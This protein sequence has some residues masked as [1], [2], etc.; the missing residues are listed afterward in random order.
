MLSFIITD[1][2]TNKLKHI[3][4]LSADKS[5][6]LNSLSTEYR[7]AI[8]AYARISTIGSTTRIENAVLTDPEIKWLDETLRA[9]GRPTAFLKEKKYIENKLSKERERS[10]EEVA[11]CRNMLAIIYTQAPDLFP[12]TE[13]TIRGFH[14]ELL[15]F[16]PPAVHYLG[17]YK[18][19]PNNVVETI[20]GTNIKRD[21]LKTSHPGPI[22]D[23][24]MRDLVDWYNKTLPDHPWPI[25]VASEFVFRFL[26]IHP[27]QDGNGRIG[28]ALF[29]LALLQSNEKNLKIVIPYI[30]L[31]RHIEKHKEEYYL[32]LRRCSDGKFLQ[33]SGKYKLQY[34]LI[35][36]LKMLDEAIS[37]DIDFYANKYAS[38]IKLAD[39]PRKVLSCFEHYP[40]KK[41]ALKD[42]V[43]ETKI[44]RRT[45]IHALNVLVS[46]NFLQKS[47][48][49]PA[50]K[51]QITF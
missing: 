11:G 8:H 7:E 38:F 22:T 47:G 33:D 4:E 18:I 45:A 5:S 26:A 39:A 9:D 35:F 2:I 24:A 46:K 3:D 31:D 41:L 43:G 23:A 32:V 19:V 17:K 30:A 37:N 29:H 44:S 6:S 50:T 40:E 48:T 15:Q 13:T 10:I 34:F 49:G 28:R 42:V 20:V 21:I 25:A 51:Y 14:K 27:F 36:M 1:E 16:Y 12:L